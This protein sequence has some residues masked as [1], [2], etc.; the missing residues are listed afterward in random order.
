MGRVKSAPVKLNAAHGEAK[1]APEVHVQA[2]VLQRG[3]LLA[4]KGAEDAC[5]DFSQKVV[6]SCMSPAI[7]D[8]GT[9]GVPP[10]CMTRTPE[11]SNH[12]VHT[13]CLA[14]A[15]ASWVGS[16]GRTYVSHFFPICPLDKFQILSRS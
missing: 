5:T 7:S 10:C 12:N 11:D 16:L 1:S 9:P 2:P 8:Y 15:S 14:I 4:F 6:R 3:P 13:R